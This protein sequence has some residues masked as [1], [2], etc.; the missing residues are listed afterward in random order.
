MKRII[1]ALALVALPVL[2]SEAGLDD[3]AADGQVVVF[4]IAPGTG[5]GAWNDRASQINLRIGDVLRIVNNDSIVHTLHTDGAPCPHG[6]DMA[7][8]GGTR[9]CVIAK[10]FDPDVEGPL[11]DHRFPQ[12]GF[13]YLKAER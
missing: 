4:E 12:S 2:A 9:D 11:Y 8:N 6:E 10:P 7:P 1:L 13:F 5:G 3:A